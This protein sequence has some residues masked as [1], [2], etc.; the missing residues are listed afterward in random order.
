MRVGDFDDDIAVARDAWAQLVGVCPSDVSIGASASHL[1]GLVAASLPDVTRV[2]TV[3]NEFTSVTF[4]FPFVVQQHRG[5]T[6]AE[7]TY[8]DLIPR[9]REH[10]L[11]V[12]SA[13]QSADCTVMDLEELHMAA[14]ETG[15][16]VL[17]DVS[18]AA[19]WLR[20][21]LDWAHFVVG[22]GYKWLHG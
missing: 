15:A 12:I 4:P 17:V 10:D 3:R 14:G 5:V 18:Q 19:G 20:L 2:L 9:V 1:L 11:V 8:F 6:V 21:Q 13:V 16:L 22:A 7:S